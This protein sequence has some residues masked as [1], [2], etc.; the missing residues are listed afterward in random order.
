[1]PLNLEKHSVGIGLALF[2]LAIIYCFTDLF[3]VYQ[4]NNFVEKHKGAI[5]FGLSY[6]FAFLMFMFKVCIVLLCIYIFIV[7]YNIAIV[8]IFKPL[9]SENTDSNASIDSGSSARE[10]IDK[11]RVSYYEAIKYIAKKV[12]TISFGFF[13]I[14]NSIMMI[15]VI[16]PTYF[17]VVTYSYYQFI[18]TKENTKGAQEQNILSTTFFYFILL[19]FIVMFLLSFYLIYTVMGPGGSGSGNSS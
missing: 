1:M 9:I 18:A 3:S 19:L 17:L 15:F 8:G 12:F 7:L 2:L 13:S 5:Q 11:A 14:P 4:V 6:F 10:I 16:I